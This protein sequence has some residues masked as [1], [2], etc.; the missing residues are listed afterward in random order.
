M[1]LAYLRTF[2]RM[3]LS[4]IPMKAESG[5]IGGDMSHE[6]IILAETGESAV[7]CDKQ[8][9]ELDVLAAAPSFE[10]DLDPFFVHHTGIYAAT[11]EKHDPATCP[12]PPEQLVTA[13]GIEVGHIFYFGTKYSK[14]LGAV[15]TGPNGEPVTVE[16]GSYGIGVSRL[17]AAIIEASHD[18]NGIIWPESVAPYKVGLINLKQGDEACDRVCEDLYDDLITAGVEVLYDDRNDRPG[19]KFADMD[20]IGLPWQLVVGPRGLKSGVVELKNRKTGEKVELSQDAALAK[21]SS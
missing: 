5:P 4:A 13:R 6:F 16:M 10:D 8:W 18:D 9:V 20:L 7:F 11:E 14:P 15:V 12:L 1:F 3:G 21:L 17:V 2:A 19:V